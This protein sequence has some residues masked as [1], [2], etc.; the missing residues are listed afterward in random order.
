MM[1]LKN[2]H[3]FKRPI[4][5]SLKIAMIT[6]M[7]ILL[8]GC[9]SK[10]DVVCELLEFRTEIKEH[11]SEYSQADWEN[12]IDKY[13]NLC[14]KLDEMPFTDEERMEIEKVKGEIAG[15]AATAAMQ[16]VSDKVQ[17]IAKEIESFAEGFNNTFKTPK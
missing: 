1:L 15:Y 12:A 16:E 11:S 17:T 4:H 9:E 10:Q 5:C 7:C 3:L 14:Q 13:T 2:L 6:L 8:I